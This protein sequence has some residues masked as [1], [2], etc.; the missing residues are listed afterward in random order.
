[1]SSVEGAFG[2]PEEKQG[3]VGGRFAADD[4]GEAELDLVGLRGIGDAESE[5]G[6]GGVGI[7]RKEGGVVAGG[8]VEVVGFLGDDA[9]VNA[10]VDVFDFEE[11]DETKFGDAVGGE[12]VP[13]VSFKGVEV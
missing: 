11:I 12:G 4:I 5:G 1:M 10:A 2:E 3:E 13:A 7:I 6:G 8:G 9:A